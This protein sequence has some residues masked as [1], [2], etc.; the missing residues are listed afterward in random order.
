MLY[1]LTLE[2]V[3][4]ITGL[5]ALVFLITHTVKLKSVKKALA[6]TY[7]AVPL[8]VMLVSL[9]LVVY[10]DKTYPPNFAMPAFMH[11]HAPGGVNPDLPFSSVINFFVNK[12]RFKQ[13]QDISRDP[14]DVPAP[15]TRDATTTEIKMTV[16]EVLSEIAPDIY[17]NYW[18][19]D[20]TVPGPFLRVKEGDT[21][22]LTLTND[23]TSLHTHNI[24]LHAVTGPGGGASL[25]NVAPGETKAFSWKA[26]NP[27]LYIY[28]C[29]TPNVSSHNSHGQYGLILVEPKEGLPK[30]D[31]EFYVVQGE[32]YT[33]GELGK[34]GLM[35]FDSQALLDGKPNYVVFNGRIDNKV[36]RLKAKVGDTVR[37][38]VGNGGVN[39]ISSF[40]VIG[41]IFD[42]VYPEGAMGKGSAV[43]HNVQTTAV[44]PGGSAIVEFKVDVPGNFLLVDHAL[45]RMNK[46]AWAVLEVT[47]DKQPEIFA[48]ITTD[49]ANQAKDHINM[50]GKK[51]GY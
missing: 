27:G 13:V 9:G 32:F 51:S 20:D 25:T 40:H 29:A 24:D 28:H 23:K 12:N 38:Y 33:T 14:S 16:R 43:L 35:P 50:E 30:V 21:V 15:L 18:T 10:A 42:T 5:I 6:H 39:L 34:K 47:G 44:L 3:A 19:Y 1:Y 41:E 4:I 7:V 26:L 48:P 11:S 17:L 31:K 8:V 49:G 45:A 36:P 2:I 22:R 37:I 46:G